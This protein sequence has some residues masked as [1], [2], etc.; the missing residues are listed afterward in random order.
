MSQR[1]AARHF[2][3]SRDTVRK[4]MAYSVPPGYRRQAP[5]RRPKL[6]AFIPIIDQWL[7]ADRAVPRKQRHTAKR[8]FDRLRDEH[9]FTG[10]YTII[11]DYMRDRARRGQEM[12]V[13][14]AHPPGHAQADFGE[15]TVVIGGV[16][17]KA[18]FF[19]LDL[20]HSDACYVHAY[21]AAVAEAWVDGHIHAFAFFGAVPQSIVYD[22][23]RCLVAKIL[24]DGTRKRAALFSGFLSHYLIRDRYGRPGKGNDKGSVEGL[25]GYARRNFMVPIPRF[26]SWDAFNLWLEEQCRK[27]QGDRLRGESE[28]IGERLLR[29]LAA[30]RPLPASPFEACDQASGR[31]TSQALVRYRTNDYSVPVAFGHQDVWIRGYVDAVVIGCGGEIIARHP[32]SYAREEVVFDPLHYLPLIEQKINALDQ[33]AP[34]Q[35]WEL[36]EA[37]TTLRRL[38]EARM[39]KQGRRAYVQVLRLM[40]SFDLA[41]L[42]AAVKQALHLGAIS[43][44]AVKHLVLCRAE[45]RPPRLDLD[46]YPYLPR[47]TVEKTSAKAYMRL[48]DREEEPA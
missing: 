18:H 31:V 35:G 40:E 14:L 48:L 47:A 26:A 20:P 13:P 23:D 8:V 24:P 28:T 30:M 10:G 25:V 6:D 21:P 16:E 34:L 39:G 43:F 4:M 29:D 15:A 11:K 9:G 33:A 19:V 1:E 17:Q 2:G 3:I 37:F 12:F 38:M 22:N 42:H 46:I 7:E 45:R 27:R 44:D 36:P 5:V 32:R 41:D